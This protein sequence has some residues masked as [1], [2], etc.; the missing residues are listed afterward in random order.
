VPQPWYADKNDDMKQDEEGRFR[1]A[2]DARNT[3]LFY[4][5]LP[6]GQAFMFFA[7]SGDTIQFDLHSDERMRAHVIYTGK[8]GYCNNYVNQLRNTLLPFIRSL[9]STNLEPL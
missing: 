6:N 2:I 8:N 7:F 9:H 4:L 5:G 3:G 1:L